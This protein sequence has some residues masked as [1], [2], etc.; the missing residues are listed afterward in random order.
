MQKEHEK[1]MQWALEEA[2]LAVAKGE[3]PIGAVAVL[4]GTVV[5]RAHNLRET[6]QDPLGHAE[7]LLL[8]RLASPVTPGL[9]RGPVLDAG[10]GA[11][12][13]KMASWGV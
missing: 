11:G 2:G 4:G 12:M 9:T 10:S 6:T 13:T 1:Y 5:A 7:I 3:V 8:R